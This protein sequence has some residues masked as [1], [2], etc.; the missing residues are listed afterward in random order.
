MRWWLAHPGDWKDAPKDP[1]LVPKGFPMFMARTSLWF[2][3]G[4]FFMLAADPLIVK[5]TSWSCRCPFPDIRNALGGGGGVRTGACK[6]SDSKD[7]KPKNRR[8]KDWL[9]H[10]AWGILRNTNGHRG[11][12]RHTKKATASLLFHG[13]VLE[14]NMGLEI[15]IKKRAKFSFMTTITS[16]P[17]HKSFQLK[18]NSS[19]G[20]QPAWQTQNDGRTPSAYVYPLGIL[21]N[22]TIHT[23]KRN[24]LWVWPWYPMI[25]SGNL[26]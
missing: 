25:P 18:N 26:T 17:L 19:W 20:H 1:M 4:S 6:R 23:R 2:F 12:K 13:V 24:D 7:S 21:K 15:V 10:S 22:H 11:W 3:L 16:L 5:E 14:L 9:K 8:T